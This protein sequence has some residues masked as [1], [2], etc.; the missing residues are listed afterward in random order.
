MAYNYLYINILRKMLAPHIKT[1]ILSKLLIDSYLHA[2]MHAAER[3]RCR[4]T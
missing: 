3:A 2:R 4:A 1:S